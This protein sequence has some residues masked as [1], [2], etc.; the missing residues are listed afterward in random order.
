MDKKRLIATIFIKNGI[1][2]VGKNDETPVGEPEKIA[3]MFNDCGID[4]IL[5]M[6]ISETAEGHKQ[7][8]TTI[9]EIN[10]IL[11]VTA[12]GYGWIKTINDVRDYMFAGCEKVILN[13]S[14]PEINDLIIEAGTRYGKDKLSLCL[15]TVDVLF[16]QKAAIEANFDDLFLF[17]KDII[18]A[19]EH[20]TEVPYYAFIEGE[21]IAPYVEAMKNEHCIGVGGYILDKLTTDIM[22]LKYRFRDM[23]IPVYI[24]ESSLDWSEFKLDNEGLIAVVTQDY[25]TNEVLNYGYMDEEAFN[26]TM[27]SGKMAYYNKETKQVARH[28]MGSG[29]YQYVKS[30]SVDC[31]KQVLLAKI[32]QVGNAC[33]SGNYSCFFTEILRKDY[34]EKN[35]FKLL[36]NKYNNI[37]ARKH[38]PAE[39]SA[40]AKLFEQGLNEILRKLQ[41]I[42]TEMTLYAKD[43]DTDA[44]PANIADLLYITMVLMCEYDIRWD[45]ITR[46]MGER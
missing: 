38:N 25:T 34:V 9:K 21:D 7:S 2:V 8:L 12:Y 10:R 31:H 41:N 24:F 39:G 18:E 1:L 6:D 40:T 29:Q 43:A 23:G 11:E 14:N 42:T 32:S 19:V 28:G 33:H 5:L 37:S 4:N 3:R 46:E 20:M 27:S 16:K 30:L 35:I 15:D 13:S 45:D 44:L 22:L 26:E 17:S 36:E